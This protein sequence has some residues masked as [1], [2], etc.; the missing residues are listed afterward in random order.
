MLHIMRQ[1]LCFAT[2]LVLEITETATDIEKLVRN[3]SLPDK[4]L[5]E[6]AKWAE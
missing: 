5:R 2:K 1:K 3:T 4:Q 6:A